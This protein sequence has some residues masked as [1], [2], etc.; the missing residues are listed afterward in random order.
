M[1]ASPSLCSGCVACPGLTVDMCRFL[2]PVDASAALPDRSD[3]AAAVDLY[4]QIKHT[5]EQGI[6]QTLQDREIDPE[7]DLGKRLLR[8]VQRVVPSW[9][10]L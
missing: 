4:H 3:T 7:R 8:Q 1:R 10:L 9:E 2:P 5:V 6:R